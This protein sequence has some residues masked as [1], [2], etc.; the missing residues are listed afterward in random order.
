[1]VKG[2]RTLFLSV[3]SC[4]S[5]KVTCFEDLHVHLIGKYGG[6][7]RFLSCKFRK[8]SVIPKMLFT[9]VL[10]S[11]RYIYRKNQTI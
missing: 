9:K 5:Q 4:F 11:K 3:F 10:N 8:K 6:T 7:Q 1:M 2:G